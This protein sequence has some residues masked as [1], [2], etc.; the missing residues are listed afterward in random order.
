[1]TTFRKL[2]PLA[3][4]AGLI[5]SSA[6]AAD[7]PVPPPALVQRIEQ[8]LLPYVRTMSR[9]VT[10]WHWTHRSDTRIPA[11]G[12]VDSRD[13]NFLQYLDRRANSYFRMS[14]KNASNVGTGLYF[15]IDPVMTESYGGKKGGVL[16]QA[17]LAAGAR[18]I[19][20]DFGSM[21]SSELSAELGSFG[22][23]YRDFRIGIMGTFGYDENPAC[24]AIRIAIA[25]SRTLG[26]V[27]FRYAYS[28]EEFSFCQ[29]RPHVAFN[30]W[31]TAAFRNVKGLTPE[32]NLSDPATADKALVRAYF[33]DARI[34]S[35]FLQHFVPPPPSAMPPL[36]YVQSYSATHLIGCGNYIEDIPSQQ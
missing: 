10:L 14:P 19:V 30:F 20:I 31:S 27:G 24:E 1:M 34:D 3:M 11:Q 4:V 17:E 6:G 12:I 28:S 22:C 33:D 8:E 21:F 23:G 29:S 9:P 25:Q 26:A 13:P 32:L 7:I 5:T 18:I 35:V 16:V 2:L 36:S 15:A